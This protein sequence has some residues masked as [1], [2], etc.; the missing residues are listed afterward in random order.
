MKIYRNILLGIGILFMLLSL[1]LFAKGL[2][3][4][5]AEF[6]VPEVVLNSAHYYDAIRWVYI[7]QFV[8]GLLIAML[9]FSVTDL[10][11][12]KLICLL[13]FFVTCIYTY[14]DFKNSD[15]ALGNGLYQGASSVIP[16]YISLVVNL[17]LLMTY[18]L[19]RKKK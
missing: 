8:L 14:L 15:S 5:M 1:S 2:V 10:S 18:F 7:H 17:L 4:S 13:L 9:G 16:A 19:L 6:K 11:K 3:V 12:Q